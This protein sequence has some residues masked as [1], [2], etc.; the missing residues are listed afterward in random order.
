MMF[1]EQ[2]I[3]EYQALEG[4]KKKAIEELLARRQEIDRQ[5]EMLGPA[6]PVRRGRKPAVE[7]AVLREF[8]E[9]ASEAKG[10]KN[11]SYKGSTKL[12][13]G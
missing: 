12:A 3:K 4:K 1:A 11:A 13:A 8:E 2:V 6:Q 10:S 7:Q 5:L 9:V